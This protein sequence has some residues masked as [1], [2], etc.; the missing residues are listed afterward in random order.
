MTTKTATRKSKTATKKAAPAKAKPAPK[1]AG[2]NTFTTVDLA[3]QHDMQAKT[4]RARIR[5]NID[6]WKPLFKDGV[7]HVFP[8]NKT[9][10]DKANALLA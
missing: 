6:D 7:K 1:A 8:D 9:T 5:R 2:G 3:K 4:L 10:R